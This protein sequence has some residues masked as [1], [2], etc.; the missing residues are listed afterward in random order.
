MRSIR[1]AVLVLI[2]PL[3]AA[4][5]A[6]APPARA[7]PNP[8]TR[9]AKSVGSPSQGRLVG[10]RP[11]APSPEL[12]LIGYHRWGVPELAGMVE[13]AAARVAAAH[14]GAVLT[15]GDLSREG[16]GDVGGHRSHESGRDVDL[17]F[18]LRDAKGR[19]THAARFATIDPEGRAKGLG[20]VSF[21]D[22]ANWSLVAALLTDR[23]AR[24]LQI[25]V[26][27]PL[28]TRLLRAAARMGAPARLRERAA[29]VMLQPRHAL[30]HDNHFHVRIGCPRASPQCRAFARPAKVTK[31]RALARRG[32]R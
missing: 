26:A 12:R 28:R 11:L 15:V 18:Y 19:P 25:F 16:G 1:L 24:V 2:A 23:E 5:G 32:P 21:D 20:A 3:F 9:I 10:G 4:A 7:A 13:R 31:A 6:L 27:D 17:G 22:A 8:K 30:P 14:P 29:R